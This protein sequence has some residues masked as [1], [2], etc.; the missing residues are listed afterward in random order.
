MAA[1]FRGL[2]LLATACCFSV[3]AAAASQPQAVVQPR[4]VRETGP[5]ETIFDQLLTG[6]QQNFSPK[7]GQAAELPV[8]T[9][10]KCQ[11]IHAQVYQAALAVDEKW[12]SD[13]EKTVKLFESLQD[14]GEVT[15]LQ[16]DQ[17]KSMLLVA[18]NSVLTYQQTF[19]DA[20]DD[21]GKTTCG[22]AAGRP[23]VLDD[24]ACREMARQLDR[25][26]QVL[27]DVEAAYKGLAALEA[28]APEKLRPFLLGMFT[29]DSAVRGTMFAKKAPLSWKQWSQAANKEI[30][31]R[32]EDLKK[33]RC[34]L[35][36]L[37]WDLE[38]NTLGVPEPQSLAVT[39]ADFEID[40]GSLEQALRRYE[41]RPWEQAKEDVR[42]EIR[43]KVFRAV[44]CQTQL[45]L[46]WPR[47]ERFD[48]LEKLW[49]ALPPVRLK[50]IDLANGE[51]HQAQRAAV[52]AALAN[53]GLDEPPQG[54]VE[55]Q[56]VAH[57][58]PLSFS[59]ECVPMPDYLA[60][61]SAL[62]LRVDL[63]NARA[64]L[65]EASREVRERVDALSGV[66]NFGCKLEGR[67]AR[68]RTTPLAFSSPSVDMQPSLNFQL[69]L[70]RLAQR[71]AYRTALVNYQQARHRLTELEV[72]L[73]VEVRDE[74][75]RLHRIPT[76]YTIQPK[77]LAHYYSHV[78]SALEIVLTPLDASLKQRGPVGGPSCAALTAEYVTALNNLNTQQ[79]KMY[80]YWF[81]YLVK[82]MALYINLG[83]LPWTTDDF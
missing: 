79:N 55:Q 1:H 60:A 53:L 45:V 26:Y 64:Q 66:S 75:R 69:P 34:R 65:L 78:E 73:A 22:L 21:P 33:E 31:A 11:S 23:L 61:E 63:M 30:E 48:H 44:V 35:L 46:V 37:N 18:R 54:L 52:K 12:A 56:E 71:N 36:D 72:S 67:Y 40:I 49:P 51:L 83:R 5:I 10:K 27:A 9:S 76:D 29:E 68:R 17:A 38:L 25:Y 43:T 19:A 59:P 8:V 70:N 20:L 81:T 24:S 14:V 16:V 32:L 47:K 41:A 82:R 6:H 13:L 39:T 4:S 62:T 42:G 77:V 50:D 15:P 3:G 2:A 58:F 57:Y 80:D 7:Q 28:V 74:V